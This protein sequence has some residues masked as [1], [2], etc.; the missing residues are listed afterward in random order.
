MAHP[1]RNLYSALFAL[2]LLGVSLAGEPYVHAPIFGDASVFESFGSNGGSL[3]FSNVE[4]VV[5]ETS[6]ARNPSV[7]NVSVVTQTRKIR[8]SWANVQKPSKDDLIV[9]SCADQPW[10]LNE[11]FDAV[12]ISFF[13]GTFGDHGSI[14]LPNRTVLPDLRCQYV[15]R[16][17]RH[18]GEFGSVVA[19]GELRQDFGI[20]P[21][22]V[23]LAFTG[24]R[25]EMLVTWVTGDAKNVPQVKWGTVSGSYTHTVS[26][27]SSTYSADMMC[28]A[29][30]NTTGP[31]KFI[32]PGTFTASS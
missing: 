28:N 30:A 26:G 5:I 6:A 32:H 3:G 17:V 8:V 27:K 15:F 21:T 25:T 16:Y 18:E 1:R 13:A 4:P 11:G 31:T 19:E 20:R 7:L 14:D 2:S 9:L 22:Q 29:P 23:H 12:K 24:V 10:S